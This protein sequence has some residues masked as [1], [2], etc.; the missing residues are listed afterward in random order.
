MDGMSSQ[1]ADELFEYGRTLCQ[2]ER[3]AEAKEQLL[4]SDE[5]EHLKDTYYWLYKACKGLGQSDDAM[6]YLELCYNE[7]DFDKSVSMLYAEE[8][9]E[10][11]EYKST[12]KVL[13]KLMSIHGWDEYADEL[14]DDIKEKMK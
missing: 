8:L 13:E 14:L 7:N 11:G 4:L 12:V 1:L 2:M 3:Y 6:K 10:H 9:A 5:L